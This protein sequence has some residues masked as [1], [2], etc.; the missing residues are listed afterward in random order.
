MLAITIQ[1]I[2][3]HCTQLR[4]SSSKIIA[5]SA[6]TAGSRLIKMLKTRGGMRRK[7]ISSKL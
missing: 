4:N 7:A 2:A 1:A 6:A 5:A 3:S